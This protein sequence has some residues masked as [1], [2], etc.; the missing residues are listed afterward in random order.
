MRYR[1]IPSPAF[2]EALRGGSLY[3]YNTVFTYAGEERFGLKAFRYTNTLGEEAY[4]HLPDR[5]VY[6]HMFLDL[7]PTDVLKVEDLL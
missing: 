1:I 7:Y 6:N 2:D 4:A 5:F 3:T